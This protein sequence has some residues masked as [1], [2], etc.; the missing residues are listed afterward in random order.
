MK[1]NAERTFFLSPGV[2]A[3]K[4]KPPIEEKT[5]KQNGQQKINFSKSHG[6]DKENAKNKF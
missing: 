2:D 1:L 3:P 5:G 6:L 4:K